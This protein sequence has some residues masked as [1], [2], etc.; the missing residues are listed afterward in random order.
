MTV[1]KVIELLQT[2]APNQTPIDE[3][4]P[5]EYGELAG[6]QKQINRLK[7]Y[8]DKVDTNIKTK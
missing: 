8:I 5:F 3:L 2:W 4:T 6:M 7:A 1:E